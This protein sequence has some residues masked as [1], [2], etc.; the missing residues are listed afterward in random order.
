MRTYD[1]IKGYKIIDIVHE[2]EPYGIGRNELVR[3]SGFAKNT[4]DRWIACLRNFGII[5]QTPEYPI[6][7]TEVSI[8]KYRKDSLLL[9]L[10]ARRKNTIKI[11]KNIWN[12][13]NKKSI[14]L[15]LSLTAFGAYKPRKYSKLKAGLYPIHNPSNLQECG[16]Y[17]GKTIS[18]VSLNDVV[19]RVR[20]KSSGS[21]NKRAYLPNYKINYGNNRLFGY[22]NLTIEESEGIFDKLLN[23]NPP[24]IKPLK[25]KYKTQ[26]EIRYTFADDLL[27]EFVENCILSFNVNVNDRLEIAYIYDLF[28]VFEKENGDLLKKGEQIKEYKK[29]MKLWYGTG[30]KTR[31]YFIKMDKRKEELNLKIDEKSEL[32]KHFKKVID[33]RDKII[34]DTHGD[35]LK[36]TYSYLFDDKFEYVNE[37]YKPLLDKYGFIVDI[38]LEMLFPPFLREMWK[39]KNFII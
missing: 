21:P 20:T 36:D 17:D 22:L 2:R 32:T 33:E 37:K 38:F 9:P 18:Y 13:K 27:K 14:I 6:Y 34:R 5:K 11:R 24:I 1:N 31:D 26:S 23:H 3:I 30:G 28:Y 29:Y 25:M 7:L 10:D 12:E 15:I 39:R 4:V 35:Q 19:S 16:M 8:Q